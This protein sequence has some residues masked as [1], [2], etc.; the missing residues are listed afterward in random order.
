MHLGIGAG[1]RG[2][3]CASQAPSYN[4]R[5]GS[6]DLSSSDFITDGQIPGC[7]QLCKIQLPL[8]GPSPTPA[9]NVWGQRSLLSAACGTWSA[10]VSPNPTFL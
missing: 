2:I 7:L 3:P 9:K 1:V 4:P 5:R 8:P 10:Q 6:L